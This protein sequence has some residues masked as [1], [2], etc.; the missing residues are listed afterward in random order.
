MFQDNKKQNITHSQYI[1]EI[2]HKTYFN[3]SSD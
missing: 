3:D 1:F 2:F